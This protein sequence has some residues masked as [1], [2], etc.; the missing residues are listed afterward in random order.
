[1][2][3]LEAR[4]AKMITIGVDAHKQVHAAAALDDSGRELA[5]WRGPNSITGW[6]ELLEWAQAWHSELQWGIE[7]GWGYGR[8][9][10]Q[11]LVTAGQRTYEVNARWTALGRRSIDHVQKAE[12][13]RQHY[14][15]VGAPRALVADFYKPRP[16]DPNEER[17]FQII[18]RF[19]L[20]FGCSLRTEKNTP[21]VLLGQSFS[22]KAA[23]GVGT[24]GVPV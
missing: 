7:G 5:N 15:F 21:K 9:L 17:T 18:E 4:S 13:D 19:G 2:A 24:S 8:G 6:E 16:L 11:F 20:S 1:M 12:L 3:N 10:A 23:Y 14:Q 22:F